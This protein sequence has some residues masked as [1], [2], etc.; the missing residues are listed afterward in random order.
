MALEKIGGLWWD[1]D[2]LVGDPE[3]TAFQNKFTLDP[4]YRKSILDE[5]LKHNAFM[6]QAAKE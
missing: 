1:G 4:D 3:A 5:C 2:Q 6:R